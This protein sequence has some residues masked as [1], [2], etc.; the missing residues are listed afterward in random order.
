MLFFLTGCFDLCSSSCALQSSCSKEVAS[1][2]NKPTSS[3]FFRKRVGVGVWSGEINIT[4]LSLLS[5]KSVINKMF[6]NAFTCND[7]RVCS[8]RAKFQSHFML[9]FVD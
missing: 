3:Q 9:V 8:G 4:F 7:D 5:Y 6:I 1:S 2:L